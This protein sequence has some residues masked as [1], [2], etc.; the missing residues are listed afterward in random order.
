VEDL[1]YRLEKLLGSS[2]LQ[3]MA[4]AARSLARPDAAVRICEAVIDRLE[5][6]RESAV[7]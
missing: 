1:P 6:A 7:P 3:E 5:R 2:K 4:A